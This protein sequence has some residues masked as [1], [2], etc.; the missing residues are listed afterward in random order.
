VLAHAREQLARPREQRVSLGVA[1]FSA[2]QARAIR[3]RLETLRRDEPAVEPFF[4]LEGAEP[5]FVKNLE[6]VQGDERDVIFISL[7]YGRT[8]KGDV[9]LNFGPLNLDGGER[10][11]NVLITRA[12]LRC[13]VFSNIRAEDLDP[14]RT[15]S[16]GL[17]ALRTFLAYAEHGRFEGEEATLASAEPGSAFEGA[18]R[19]AL[20][21]SGH[22][23]RARV[24]SSEARVD[25]AVEDPDRPGRYLLAIE[26]DGSDALA[27]ASSRERE[28][29]R[30]RMLEGLGWRLHRAWSPDW[31]RD[32][33]QALGRAL[34]A[35][36]EAR[37][38]APPIPV[39]PAEVV[40][41]TEDPA[42]EAEP[43]AEPAFRVPAYR[44]AELVVDLAGRELADTTLKS[45]VKWVADVVDV[46]GPV[47]V[48]E[49]MRRVVD[50]AGVKRLGSRI[51]SA[52]E[53]AIATAVEQARC[54]RAGDFLW[55]VDRAEPV[56]RDRSELPA[57]SRALELIA[58]E[59][60]AL[61]IE[62]VV[63]GAFGMEPDAIP[64]AAARLMGF[65]RAT[66]EMKLVLEARRDELITQ[67]RLARRGEHLVI[68]EL[69]VAG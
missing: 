6:N 59:E 15:S 43:T 40:P 52:L 28:R 32:P 67:G 4:A 68:P 27:A 18:V 38:S 54:R 33:A 50:A 36:A 34:S 3:D 57:A 62:T 20:A 39:E 69:R 49:V 51:Q 56:V 60:V 41:P 42:E 1:A 14:G 29:L 22:R 31:Y 47:H 19:D 8:A 48:S 5:F 53:Q 10:R 65:S 44:L 21:R 13:E 17:H 16:R 35:I 24:G 45:R 55:P 37:Q 63:Q 58:P 25:L 26:A 64:A 9:P 30:P 11:L 66:D 46:E 7:G 2:V 23:I 12:R 61:A